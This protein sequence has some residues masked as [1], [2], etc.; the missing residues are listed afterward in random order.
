VELVGRL[1]E[2]L[3]TFP[4]P[5]PLQGKRARGGIHLKCETSKP[6]WAVTLGGLID[7]EELRLPLEEFRQIPCWQ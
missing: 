1:Q 2:Q 7:L 6:S 3:S 4:V 5:E